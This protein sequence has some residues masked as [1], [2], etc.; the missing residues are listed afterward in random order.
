MKNNKKAQIW[1]SAV[2]YILIISTS[3]FLILKVGGSVMEGMKDESSLSKVKNTMLTVDK[4]IQEVANEGHGSQRVIPIEIKDGKLK[5]NN[6]ELSW[7]LKTKTEVI[8][9][10][11]SLNLGNLVISSN[12]NVNTIE[13][14]N[15]FTMQTDIEGDVFNVTIKKIGSESN[16]SS[17]NTSDL[18]ESVYYNGERLNGTFTFNLN[19]DANSGIG[20]GYTY[21]I[22]SGNNTNLG[23]AKVITHLNTT[24]DS[25]AIEYDIIYTLESFADFLTIEIKNVN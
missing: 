25:T 12:A 11:T 15:R 8:E 9:E 20:N 10:R 24:L 17:I 5:I 7:E 2:L 18:I 1:I 14:P 3:I 13:Y 4:T 6:N 22:P 19:D 16:Y 21:M 23:R